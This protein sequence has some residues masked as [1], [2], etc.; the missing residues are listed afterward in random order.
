ML[1]YLKMTNV[2]PAPEMELELGDRLN[3]LTGDNGLGKSFLLDIAWWALTNSW[4]AEINPKLPTGKKALPSGSGHAGIKA[5]YVG[6]FPH[7]DNGETR[8]KHGNASCTATYR[9][10]SG[11]LRAMSNSINASLVLYALP[12]GSF[13]VWDPARNRDEE[14]AA[15]VF[16]QNEVW[17]GLTGPAGTSRC[18]G[19]INDWANWY[20]ESNGQAYQNLVA[21]LDAL[22]PSPEEK[23]VPGELTRISLDDVRDIP[24]IRMPYGQNVPLVHAS[25]G[26]RRIIALA[27][28]LVW[29][30]EEHQKA[31]KFLD[32][33]QADRIIFIVDEIE[34]H[35]HP[36]WQ[37]CILQA[38]LSVTERIAPS[39]QTQMIVTTHSPLVMA[40]LEP[41]FD[42]AKDAWFDLDLKGSDVCLTRR[43]FE[44]HGDVSNWLT[45][46]AFDLKSPRNID[47]EGLIEKASALLDKQSLTQEEVQKMREQLISSLDCKD[48]F[49]FR[50]RAICEK[51]GL[52]Q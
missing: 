28:I 14:R 7:R 21:V 26:M 39:V 24:T 13:A 40:S 49:L 23:L 29:A 36:R 43:E 46:E 45:S 19:L 18:N 34:S 3:I 20:R 27:Y 11:W 38:L 6:Y 22:S 32:T 50:W 42:S 31:S 2:G 44:K 47:A 35:L 33:V 12:D 17:D 5:T 1:K 37:R 4:P 8:E 16:S 51:K 30:W 25:A 9:H 15:Y 41:V 48:P 52:L 10:N